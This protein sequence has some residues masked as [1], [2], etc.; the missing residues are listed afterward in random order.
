M[1]PERIDAVLERWLFPRTSEMR[2]RLL[3]IAGEALT[4]TNRADAA[5]ELLRRLVSVL[6]SAGG[7]AVVHATDSEAA[8]LRVVGDVDATA[9]GNTP[10]EVETYV[11]ALANVTVP[12]LIENLSLAH[13]IRLLRCGVVLVCPLVGREPQAVF[14]LAPRRGWLYDVATVN[15]LRVFS[16]QAGLALEN[17]AL[18]SARAH[19]EK[20][21]ALGEA[22]ARI[23]HEIRNPLTAARSL[24]QQAANADGVADL[25]GPAVEELD[26][27]GRLVADLL[28]FARRD[29]VQTRA[30]VDLASVCRNAVV[31]VAPLAKQAGVDIATDVAP[32]IVAGDQTRLVQVV[33]NLCRNAIEALAEHTPPRR[34]VVDCAAE[35]GAATITVRDNGPGIPRAELARIFEPFSTS[36]SAG[37]G[38]GLPIARR[39]VEAHG[40]RLAVESV[41]GATTVFRV[42]L[43]LAHGKV[44][45]V[46]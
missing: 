34:V 40:G 44:V 28:A 3:A 41:P 2:A 37:T 46:E 45:S 29:E 33:A 32:V 18:A 22:A 1:L 26:R 27:I 42:D 25:A 12:R 9:L 36:K 17:L 31:Q 15:A 38:L 6:D 11:S 14:L 16:S 5:D 20:L 30:P 13:Q 10:T 7:V 24:V 19:A 39:I 8:A 21:A 43:P 35:T 23:A 4:A